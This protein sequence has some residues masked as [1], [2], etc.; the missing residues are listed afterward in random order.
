M[1]IAQQKKKENIIEYILYMW[2]VEE[3]IRANKLDMNLI[4]QNIISG[5]NQSADMILEIRDWWAN[6]V[7]MMKLEQKEVKG[8]LQININTVFDVNQL[9]QR[10]LNAPN[11]VAY[12]HNFQKIVPFLKEFDE[13][14]GKA[15]RNDVDICLTALYTT[16][17]LKMKKEKI[18]E[19]TLN[20]VKAIGEFLPFLAKKYKEEQEGDSNL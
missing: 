4:D 8:H 2:Q 17:I 5:Y 1:I 9:H 3:L 18:S 6:L 12:K 13:K 11:E 20:A 10:L 14:S 7:E 15:L 16:F 19:G